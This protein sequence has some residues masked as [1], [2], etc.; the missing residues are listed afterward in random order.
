MPKRDLIRVVRTQEG[1][2][3]DPTGKMPGRGAYLCHNPDCW[4][5]ASKSDIL[6][7]ALRTI[8]TEK[9]RELLRESIPQ[10]SSEE[11]VSTDG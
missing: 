8:L 10:P 9:D 3:I 4:E 2:A 6:A 7:R 1:I 5:I 11:Q